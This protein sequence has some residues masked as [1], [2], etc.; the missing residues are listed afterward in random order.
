MAQKKIGLSRDLI[1][2]P[3]ETIADILEERE[4]TQSEL[5]ALTG[6]SCAYISKV[7]AGEK[8]ISKKLAKSLEY[9][10]KIPKTF[11]LNL[12]AQYDSEMA[13]Y[14][15]GQ[16][17]TD[18]ERSVAKKLSEVVKYLRET[19]GLEKTEKQDDLVL[20]LRRA[21]QIS[22]LDNLNQLAASG[23]Y[24][25][26]DIQSVNPYVLGA[27]VRLCQLSFPEKPASVDFGLESQDS[28][29]QG[30]KEIMLKSQSD[31]RKELEMFFRSRGIDFVIMK[32]FPGA[33]VNGYITKKKSGR[34]QLALTVRRKYADIFW[35]SLFH[36]LGHIF[37]GDLNKSG[38]YLDAGSNEIQELAADAFAR[39][40]LLDEAAFQ[41]FIQ[42]AD[43]TLSAIEKFA[44]S[45][46]VLPYIV[47]GRLQ[48]ESFIPY[49]CYASE[50]IQYDWI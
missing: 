38:K 1:I 5:A 14:M 16:S 33:P 30:L 26:T 35:F 13:E 39:N 24:R 49:S 31:V 17:V 7:L 21:L 47:I 20:S 9:A 11:W 40:A 25:L 6:V 10:L 48:K 12:Q 15:D 2:H 28:I 50:K 29:V 41:Q 46:S 18:Q 8:D 19:G 43:F 36:E 42:H 45:Q 22:K 23:M 3:G 32:S 44:Q 34:Y 4:M 37:N 27:W